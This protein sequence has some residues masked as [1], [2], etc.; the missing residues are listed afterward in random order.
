[1][2]KSPAEN[3]SEAQ[4]RDAWARNRQVFDLHW[5]HGATQ[6]LGVDGGW[7]TYPCAVVSTTDAAS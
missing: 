2:D 4:R 6:G 3:F 5:S 1:M 7:S